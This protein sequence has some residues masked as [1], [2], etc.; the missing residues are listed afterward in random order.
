MFLDIF[1]NVFVYNSFDNNSMPQYSKY[2]I[3]SPSNN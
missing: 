3:N 2:I 1:C